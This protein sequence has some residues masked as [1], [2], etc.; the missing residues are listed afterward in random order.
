MVMED[1]S[2]QLVYSYLYL[3]IYFDKMIINTYNVTGLSSGISGGEFIVPSIYAVT[4]SV[5]FAENIKFCSF[6]AYKNLL[7]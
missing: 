7:F 1:G 2:K 5:V 4:E 3:Y 6:S